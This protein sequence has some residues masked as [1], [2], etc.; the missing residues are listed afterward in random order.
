M[1]MLLRR[2]PLRVPVR[3]PDAARGAEGAPDGGRGR[4]TDLDALATG[5]V[6]TLLPGVGPRPSRESGS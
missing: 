4:A 6:D 1:V 2:R 5:I 3:V